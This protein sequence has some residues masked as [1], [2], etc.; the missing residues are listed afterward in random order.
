MLQAIS[1]KAEFRGLAKDSAVLVAILFQ[2]YRKSEDPEG[3]PKPQLEGL[4]EH[5]FRWVICHWHLEE[6]LILSRPI[7]FQRPT[8]D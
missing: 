6:G 7:T 1:D 3:W 8:V 2:L 4:I 5:F